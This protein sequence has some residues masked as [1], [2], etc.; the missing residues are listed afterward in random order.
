MVVYWFMFLLALFGLLVDARADRRSQA[1]YW[2]IIVVLFTLLIG[3]RFHV[4]CDWEPYNDMLVEASRSDLKV[5]L[6]EIT[7]PGYGLLLWLAQFFGEEIYFANVVCAFLFVVG[8]TRF[9]R[10]QP[11]PSLALLVAVPYLIIVV[12][13]GYTRQATALGLALWGF[14]LLT[15][16]R[17]KVAGLLFFVATLFHSTVVVLLPLLVLGIGRKRWIQTVAITALVVWIAYFGTAEQF[18]RLQRDYVENPYGQGSAGALPRVGLTALAGAIVI[19]GWYSFARRWEGAKLW[20]VLSISAILLL[21]AISFADTAVDRMALYL[22][23]LQLVVFSRLP[24]VAAPGG[25]RAALLLAV[26][27]LAAAVQ[28]A[29]LNYSV[30]APLCWVPYRNAFFELGI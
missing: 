21:P 18:D 7:D 22:L 10:M 17:P 30:H 5:A 29:W 14:T 19:V 13:M 16:G 12:A 2:G 11:A 27:L 3:F 4:G 8:V 23:P 9:A 6:T 25:M 28:F 24:L 20:L 1:L 15:E 26:V